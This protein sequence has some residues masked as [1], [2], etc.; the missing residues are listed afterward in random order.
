M[1]HLILPFTFLLFFFLIGN[2]TAQNFEWAKSMGGIGS[3][4]GNS[5]AVDNSGNVYTTGSFLRTVDF[6]PGPGT[7][8]LTSAGGTTD[9]FISKLDTIGNFVWAKKI[10]GMRFNMSHSIAVD[11]TGNV[12]FT[13]Q[14]MDTVD[15]NP[16]SG[17][18][19]LI[20]AGYYNMFVCKLDASGNF[21][22][23]KNMGG[24]STCAGRSIAVDYS[25]NVYTTGGFTGTI[26]FDPDTGI[27]NLSSA[28]SGDIFISKL[29]S[30]GNFV[31][32]KNMGGGSDS[33]IGH[34][35]AIDSLGNVYSTGHFSGTADFDPGSAMFNLNSSGYRDIFVSKL[36]ASGNF[37]WAK[38]MG[39][40]GYEEGLSIAVGKAGNVYT[41]GEF[42]GTVDF[43]PDIGIFNLTSTGSKDIFLCKLDSS[44]NF[45]WAKQ[46]G[47]LGDDIGNS[48][49]MDSFGNTYLTGKFMDTAD[50]D[51]GTGSFNLNSSGGYDIFV[52]KLDTFGNFIWAKNMGGPGD[53]IG[54][55]IAINPLGSVFTTGGFEGTV[56]FDP[57]PGSFNFTTAGFN[58]I[59]VS[60]WSQCYIDTSLST[61]L[62]TLMANQ[63]GAS[64]QWLNCDSSFQAISWATGLIFTPAING[65]YACEISLNGCVDTTACVQVI[66]TGIEKNAF[67]EEYKIYPNPFADQ[68]TIESTGVHLNTQVDVINIKGQVVYETTTLLNGKTV[69][70]TADWSKGI[71]FVRLT[72]EQGVGTYKLVHQ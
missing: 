66:V 21:V 17:T 49:A 27:Y 32:A 14:F 68:I 44:G 12:Y 51:P 23:A 48:I 41:T 34:S 28:G 57:G 67:S 20:S 40:T 33:E 2:T 31:W 60:K 39:G 10:G 11:A 50:F 62:Q 19:N 24:L 47:G 13:G 54:S 35:I 53:D 63:Q 29:D 7:F 55:S 9:I 46:M 5:I 45:I 64:Y 15:F 52:S 43:N 6:D 42:S 72:N 71:Y 3:D 69:L 36:D 30:L 18:F 56:D 38:G 70:N 25:G 65:S 59:F 16:G 22:W 4:V 58:D 1:K 26:D 37:L 8:N 61:N